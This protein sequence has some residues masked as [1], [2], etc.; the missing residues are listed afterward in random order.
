MAEHSG[1]V[2]AD[3]SERDQNG[4]VKVRSCTLLYTR[5]LDWLYLYFGVGEF[6]LRQQMYGFE[7][8]EEDFHIGARVL[9]KTV[10]DGTL[11]KI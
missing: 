9:C 3:V 4:H 7:Q 10:F 6:F 2:E 5:W 8:A 1:A 11:R